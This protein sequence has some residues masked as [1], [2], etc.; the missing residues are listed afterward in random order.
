MRDLKRVY[1]HF[2]I[3]HRNKGQELTK[4]TYSSLDKYNKSPYLQSKAPLITEVVQHTIKQNPHRSIT[5]SKSEEE[6]IQ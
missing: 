2:E 6:K 3:L 1:G 5:P 4:V